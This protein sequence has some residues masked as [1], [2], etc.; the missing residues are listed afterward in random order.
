MAD[1]RVALGWR[2]LQRAAGDLDDVAHD[3]G[4]ELK[5]MQDDVAGYGE[6]WGG[7]EIGM[8]IGVTHQV[9]SEFAFEKLGDLQKDLASHAKALDGA[10]GTYR[11]NEDAGEEMLRQVGDPLDAV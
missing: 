5:S 9:V 10:A 7:D 3:L 1:E 11:D 6:P 4:R 8:L 2:K